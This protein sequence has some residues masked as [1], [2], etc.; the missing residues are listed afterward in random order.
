MESSQGYPQVI[1]IEASGN[2]CGAGV[3]VRD[4]LR[5]IQDD[6]RISFRRHELSKSGVEAWAGIN[7]AFEERRQSEVGLS[8]DPRKID[9]LGGRNR[10]Q[11]VPKLLPDGVLLPTSA[12]FTP[13]P[14]RIFVSRQI[15][16]DQFSLSAHC[17]RFFRGNQESRILQGTHYG[18]RNDRRRTD[19]GEGKDER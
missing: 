18:K 2:S 13:A 17:T 10:L 6:L 14:L 1:N 19:V 15:S 3:I 8:K 4:L 9:C 5:T 11:I 7:A 16:C 12:F